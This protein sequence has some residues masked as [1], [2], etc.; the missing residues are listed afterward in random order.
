MNHTTPNEL[1]IHLPLLSSI[2]T[3]SKCVGRGMQFGYII[4]RER[5]KS[6]RP[7]RTHSWSIEVDLGAQNLSLFTDEN[8]VVRE[9]IQVLHMIQQVLSE[10]QQQRRFLVVRFSSQFRH[11]VLMLLF[12]N[13][14][15][16]MFWVDMKA[17]TGVAVLCLVLYRSNAH[18]GEV[19]G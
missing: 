10:T 12:A 2:S 17:A 1:I 19:E 15:I 18:G 3:P 7:C 6:A 11:H 16:R 4:R 14:F 9:A 8:V 13:C 5:R